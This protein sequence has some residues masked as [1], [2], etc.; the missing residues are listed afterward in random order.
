MTPAYCI[1]PTSAME[2]LV[3]FLVCID[4]IFLC[5]LCWLNDCVQVY[6]ETV[7]VTLFSKRVFADV[8]KLGI[9]R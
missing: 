1:C 7:T 9:W 4:L 2:M 6:L 5:M 3:A 8:I